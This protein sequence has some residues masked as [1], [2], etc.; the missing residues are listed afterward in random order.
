M[1]ENSVG[2]QIPDS[3]GMIYI[4]LFVG[5]LIVAIAISMV[6]FLILPFCMAIVGFFIDISKRFW[7]G[8]LSFA[9]FIY[10]WIDLQNKWLTHLIVFGDQKQ[11]SMLL[12]KGLFSGKLQEYIHYMYIVDILGIMIGIFLIYQ[13]YNYN[14]ITKN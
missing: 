13:S 1:E 14:K 9:A 11:D 12:E 2:K 8:I 5:A 10:L 3:L 6:I 7:W 4:L